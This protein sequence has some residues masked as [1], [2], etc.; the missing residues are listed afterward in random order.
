MWLWLGQQLYNNIPNANHESY[1]ESDS[2]EYGTGEEKSKSRYSNDVIFKK[3]ISERESLIKST[4]SPY[5]I[6]D[7]KKASRLWADE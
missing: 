1:E 2:L 6:I 5:W 4:H 3:S 7:K